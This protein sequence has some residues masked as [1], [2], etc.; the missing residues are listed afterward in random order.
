MKLSQGEGSDLSPP[1][2]LCYTVQQC[3]LAVLEIAL[4]L[5]LV[6]S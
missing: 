5:G 2:L 3:P 4:W 6:S 1:G